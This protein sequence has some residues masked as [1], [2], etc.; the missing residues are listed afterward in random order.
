MPL[1]WG[2][3]VYWDNNNVKGKEDLCRYTFLRPFVAN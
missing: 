1:Q 3:F 2:I